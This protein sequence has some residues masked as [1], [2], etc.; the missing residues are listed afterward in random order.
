MSGPV[1]AGGTVLLMKEGK[2]MDAVRPQ[3]STHEIITKTIEG[4]IRDLVRAKRPQPVDTTELCS[5]VIQAGARAMADIEKLTRELHA[6]RDYLQ[7]EGERIRR[8]GARYAHLTRT[9]SASVKIITESME[10]WRQTDPP[11]PSQTGIA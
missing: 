6:A 10:R 7:S 5:D 9:A 11:P 2:T 1:E 8:E 4:E 3:I